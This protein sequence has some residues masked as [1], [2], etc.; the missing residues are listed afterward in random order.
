MLGVRMPL[1][2]DWNQRRFQ[3]LSKVGEIESVIATLKISV[4]QAGFTGRY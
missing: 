4:S 2:S 3:R 1:I